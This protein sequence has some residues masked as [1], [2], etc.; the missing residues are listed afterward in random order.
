[1]AVPIFTATRVSLLFLAMATSG[2]SSSIVLRG[3]EPAKSSFM[4]MREGKQGKRVCR[5]SRTRAWPVRESRDPEGF[6]TR[7]QAQLAVRKN[8]K[9]SRNSRERGLERA[10]GVNDREMAPVIRGGV[11]I[12]VGI[13][14]LRDE[15]GGALN[16]GRRGTLAFQS[17]FRS[18]SAIGAIRKS[19]DAKAREGNFARVLAHARG[20]ADNRESARG[21][22]S[23]DSSCR[24]AR[25]QW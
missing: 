17:L 10:R 23:S 1:M 6:D 11:Q 4:A 9:S 19:S 13:N 16:V 22:P 7:A 18:T 25:R 3:S 20:D 2:C 5:R 12:G 24:C 21:L 8:R 14:A 15:R